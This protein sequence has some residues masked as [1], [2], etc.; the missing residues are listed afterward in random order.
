MAEAEKADATILKPAATRSWATTS[1]PS[2]TVVATSG[3]RLQRPRVRTS[4]TRSNR[5]GRMAERRADGS[6]TR[7]ING[8]ELQRTY[9][10]SSQ[11]RMLR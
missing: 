9:E 7:P 1:V 10:P 2:Q 8:P 6:P 5:R 4:P 3:H 11:A